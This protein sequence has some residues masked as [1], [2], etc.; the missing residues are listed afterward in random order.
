MRF[1]AIIYCW[2]Q[3]N[4]FCVNPALLAKYSKLGI[5]IHKKF[6]EDDLDIHLD[7][8]KNESYWT[9]GYATTVQ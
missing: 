2:S 4:I 3:Q 9:T 7:G 1:L 8:A 5:D 6:I